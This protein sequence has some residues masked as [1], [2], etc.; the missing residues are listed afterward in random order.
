MAGDLRVYYHMFQHN[1][2]SVFPVKSKTQNWGFDGTGEHCGSKNAWWAKSELDT[3]NLPIHF[4]PFDG[5]NEELLGNHRKFQ[6]KINGGL[7]AKWLK[8]T[9]VHEIWK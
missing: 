2:C 6:D 3:R 8:Y 9:W 5:Y 7:L 4:I 1:M